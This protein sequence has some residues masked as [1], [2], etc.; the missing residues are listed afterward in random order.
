[1][2]M[3]LMPAAIILGLAVTHTLAARLLDARQVRRVAE[4]AKVLGKVAPHARSQQLFASRPGST[5]RVR[6]PAQ[7]VGACGIDMRR[8][9]ARWC[10]R[11]WHGRSGRGGMSVAGV[12]GGAVVRVCGSREGAKPLQPVPLTVPEAEELEL[13]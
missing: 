10:A 6:R 3:L 1:M 5:A 12:R 11:A 9:V 7:R 8:G 13:R 2:V 4:A